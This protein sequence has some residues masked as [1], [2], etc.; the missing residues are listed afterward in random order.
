MSIS[1]LHSK[2]RNLIHFCLAQDTFY[3][4]R[5]SWQLADG[6]ASSQLK[7]CR[8]E[9]SPF[10]AQANEMQDLT[11]QLVYNVKRSNVKGQ[12]CTPILAGPFRAQ[13]Q[14]APILQVC[15]TILNQTALC[16]AKFD[17]RF[18]KLIPKVLIHSSIRPLP[19][20][21]IPAARLMFRLPVKRCPRPMVP[22]GHQRK[23]LSNPTLL[24]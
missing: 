7:I 12:A 11:D 24:R 3:H 1:W 6:T 21:I 8:P 15:Y 19:Q 10:R 17:E 2:D 23:I 20:A 18:A 13:G 16:T 14:N 4:L 22:A 5:Q 9:G